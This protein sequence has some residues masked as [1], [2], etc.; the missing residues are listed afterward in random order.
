M[1]QR[2]RGQSER[3]L[4]GLAPWE[5]VWRQVQLA[6]GDGVSSA[7]ATVVLRLH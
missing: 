1:L 6:V 3:R 5:R 4:R 2:A 7:A